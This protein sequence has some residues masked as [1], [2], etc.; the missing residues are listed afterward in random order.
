MTFSSVWRHF[1]CLVK[2][3]FFVTKNGELRRIPSLMIAQEV[4]IQSMVNIIDN[5]EEIEIIEENIIMEITVSNWKEK[6]GKICSTRIQGDT[7]GH[8]CVV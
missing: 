8:T 7:G 6:L 5:A 3:I 2:D 4:E 1:F